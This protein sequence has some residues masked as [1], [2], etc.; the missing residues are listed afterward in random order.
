M[1]AFVVTP[2]S[3]EI[4][5]LRHFFAGNVS[6]TQNPC[7]S[8]Y[9]MLVHPHTHTHT[10]RVSPHIFML[11]SRIKSPWIRRA[12]TRKKNKHLKRRRGTHYNLML[13]VHHIGKIPD[14][15]ESKASRKWVWYVG[16]CLR[17][18]VFVCV[19]VFRRAAPKE[20]GAL[21]WMDV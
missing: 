7:L 11:A 14:N 19:C 8:V 10:R 17:L 1:K 15:N 9:E 21:F 16:V 3:Q 6:Y 20:F 12:L 2:P 4:C 5:L 18:C 13:R